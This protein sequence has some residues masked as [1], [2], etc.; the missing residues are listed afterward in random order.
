MALESPRGLSGGILAG[1]NK[2]Y[3]DVL[4]IEKGAYFLRAL[5]FDK[6]AKFHW[7]LV[8]VYGDAQADRKAS[9]LA[10]LARLYHDNPI[11]CLIG[12]D[13]NIIRNEKERNKPANNDHCSFMF[14]AIIE[15]AGLRELP[16]NGR[17]FTWP[18]NLPDPTYEKLDMVLMCPAWEEKYPLS[19][20]Q[21]FA[22]EIS[23]HTPLFLDTGEQ[24]K[25]EPIFR[26]EN[27]WALREGFREFV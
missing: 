11:P 13:F 27:S 3:F 16:L 24:I 6:S 18:N 5:V 4:H 23:D 15:Q 10:E 17:K 25:S 20:L 7:N 22:R 2:D 21:A 26:Y 14:N 8:A 19:I 9:F 12:G 1:I